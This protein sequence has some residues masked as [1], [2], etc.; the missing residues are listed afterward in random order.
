MSE[1]RKKIFWS[2]F[3][4]LSALAIALTA[5]M[6]F[7]EYTE[8]QMDVQNELLQT[9]NTMD[10][11]FK[12][13]SRPFGQKDESVDYDWFLDHAIQSGVCAFTAQ[14]SRS[15][16]ISQ[17]IYFT[18]AT[19]EQIEEATEELEWIASSQRPGTLESAHL[20]GSPYVWYYT[21]AETITI[22]DI[23]KVQKQLAGS[24]ALSAV[25]L[26]LFEAIAGVV[27]RLLMRWIVIPIEKAFEKQKQFVADAS[28]ELKTPVAVIQASAEAMERDDNR[29]WLANIVEEAGRMNQLIAD[30]L[31]LTRSENEVPVL[32]KVDLSRLVEKQCLIQEARIFEKNLH[33]EDHIQPDLYVM[34][35]E[36]SL[37]QVFAILLDNAIAHSS[38]NIVISLERSGRDVV[39]DVMN[40]GAPIPVDQRE[41][42]F[43]RFYR[44]DDSRN[45]SSGRYGLGLAIARNIVTRLSGSIHAG[46]KDG[47]TCFSVKLRVA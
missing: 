19:D 42:I 39:L 31:D 29:K 23:S 36:S 15:G 45:R 3:G 38:G 12:I 8:T 33:L 11:M 9:A 1:L 10:D 41:K 18:G 21:S 17:V 4:I 25:V 27:S 13:Y 32:E 43:E 46:V 14:M 20:F 2:L 37:T 34:G 6:S 7:L 26:I 40:S 35:Q 5:L 24:L 22:M 16:E 47:M 28:H 30:L 44:A